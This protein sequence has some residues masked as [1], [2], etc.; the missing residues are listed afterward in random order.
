MM[1]KSNAELKQKLLTPIKHKYI[2]L[3]K[4]QVNIPEKENDLKAIFSGKGL[5]FSVSFCKLSY[6]GEN[7]SV[8][9]H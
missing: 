3:L 8:A 5:I 4:D 7:L 1:T 6:L 2:I 9:D